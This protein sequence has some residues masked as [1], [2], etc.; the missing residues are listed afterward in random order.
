[1]TVEADLF[2]DIGIPTLSCAF[3]TEHLADQACKDEGLW[4]F[5][6]FNRTHIVPPCTTSAEEV[7]EGIAILDNALKVADPY[8]TGK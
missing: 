2:R 7:M 1:M 8:S 3:R 5:I 4:P 6:H